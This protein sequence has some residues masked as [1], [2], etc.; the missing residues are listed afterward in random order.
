MKQ[1]L[2]I[3]LAILFCTISSAF[4][5]SVSNCTFSNPSDDRIFFWDDSNT[6][7]NILNLLDTASINLGISGTDLTADVIPGGVDHNL[8]L[9]YDTNE[10]IDHTA[11]NITA[12]SGLSSGGDISATRTLDLD[13]NGLTEQISPTG[14]T[15]F[16]AIYDA[17]LAGNRKVLLDSLPAPPHTE[18]SDMPS[19]V[20]AD[21]DG[22]YYTETEI[23]STTLGSPGA[24]LVGMAIIGSPQFTTVQHIQDSFHSAGW[25]TD[26]LI[27][28]NGGETIN[29]AAGDG[30]L[31]A[32]D[33]PSVELLF[34]AWPESLAI[35]IP[36]D[37]TRYIGIEYNAGNP[38]VT[39]RSVDD[40]DRHT[41]WILGVVVNDAGTLHI[42]NAPH[43][44]GDHANNMIQ[45]S[46]ETMGIKRDDVTGGIIIGETGTRNI[47]LSA[48]FLWD[49]LNRFA[50]SSLDTS[51]SGGFDRYFRDGVGGHT[52]QDAQ[53][54][55]DNT[56]Y[57]DGSG[58]LATM[59]NNRY[60]VQWFYSELDDDVI[61]VYGI[62]Q[63]T[64]LANA[65]AQ[66]PPTDLPERIT[67]TSLLIGR[68]IFRK[69]DATAEFQTVF[70]TTFSSSLITDHGSLA[71]LA[72]DDHSQYHTDA[73]ALTW[74]GTRS[75]DDLPEGFDL[76]FTDE[77]AQDAIGTAI[78]N[79]N[80]TNIVVN[81]DDA[82]N[83]I[84]YTVNAFRTVT[85][86]QSSVLR[87]RNPADD[88]SYSIIGSAITGNRLIT[89]PLLTGADT[90]AFLGL[91]QSFTEDITLTAEAKGF[92]DTYVGYGRNVTVD[93]YAIDGINTS[94]SATRGFTA[95]FA[96]SINSI[97]FSG[98]VVGA[99]GG[100]WN[101]LTRING[102]NALSVTL[103]SAISGDKNISATAARGTHTFSAGDVISFFFDE[104]AGN[105]SITSA[106][107]HCRVQYDS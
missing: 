64:S 4:A 20:N 72:D 2:I 53:T 12:G 18:L 61:S 99:V 38:Q 65:I 49:R 95:P 27:T 13:I 8:L 92:F 7:C 74:L 84:D 15:D 105:S 77:R 52:R 16:V 55:W 62:A 25:L 47:T 29:V 91:A 42:V 14:A 89:L 90:F 59:T 54:Q 58:I 106:L 41:E 45:R 35:A 79:G 102:T 83:A 24:S 103:D 93:S 44:I 22:R 48:G 5:V 56:R 31:R 11:V 107:V 60:A 30:A 10:H 70:T 23:S 71:G 101:I 81:Y 51:I 87:I 100:S 26:G 40:F 68:L 73:R 98:T 69:D 36:T 32:T 104:T 21:H 3:F 80:Q 85:T 43:F 39:V 6:D 76:Y 78:A 17:G 94:M 57:D 96:G 9:N 34:I 88:R 75:T 86:F 67:K 19:A 50:V 33:N 66:S 37:A 97:G 28:D 1:K 63:E 82:G 46:H